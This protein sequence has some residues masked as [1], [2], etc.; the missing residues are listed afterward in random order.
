MAKH[1]GIYAATNFDEFTTEAIATQ[2]A[3]GEEIAGFFDF[4]I[5][6]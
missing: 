1:V 4:D 6:L 5:G 2:G 3:I